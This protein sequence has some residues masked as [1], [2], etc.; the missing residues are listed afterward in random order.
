M[1]A[2]FRNHMYIL[3]SYVAAITISTILGSTFLLTICNA[4][5]GGEESGGAGLVAT[6]IIMRLMIPLIALT[7]IYLHKKKDRNEYR[8]FITKT[9][10]RKYSAKQDIRD[11]LKSKDL[12][13]EVIF[14]SI[15]TIIYWAFNYIFFWIFVNIPLFI[16][17]QFVSSIRIH[18]LWLSKD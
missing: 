18:S 2:K 6:Q 12:W 15:I 16:I 4:I 9:K 8:I 7:M 1:N 10:E 17:F 3:F 14:V 11:L 13:A 5:W